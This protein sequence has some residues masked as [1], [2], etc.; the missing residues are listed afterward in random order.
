MSLFFT[1]KCS[2]CLKSRKFKQEAFLDLLTDNIFNLNI[3]NSEK[4]LM[5]DQQSKTQIYLVYYIYIFI[6]DKEKCTV[7]IFEKLEAANVYFCF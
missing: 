1:V 4:L 2:Q 6:S 5:V 7:L 3:F